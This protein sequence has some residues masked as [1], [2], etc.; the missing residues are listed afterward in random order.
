M[1]RHPTPKTAIIQK[2]C[3]LFTLLSFGVSGLVPCWAS[4]DFAADWQA[5]P[6]ID[7]SAPAVKAPTTTP[8]PASSASKTASSSAEQAALQAAL[9][10]KLKP[11]EPF[12]SSVEKQLLIAPKAGSPLIQ[13]LNTLQAVLYG[14]PRFQDAGELLGELARLFPAE[15]AKA[16]ADLQAKLQAEKPASAPSSAGKTAPKR[17]TVSN[18][19]PPTLAP[20]M[21]NTAQQSSPSPARKKRFWQ[22]EDDPFANDPFFQDQPN[23]NADSYSGTPD[24]AQQAGPSRLASIGQGLAGLAMMAGAVAGSYYLN[25][26]NNTALPQ[27]GYYNNA[28]YGYPPYG[29]PYGY[30]VGNRYFGPIPGQVPYGYNPVYPYAYPGGMT[31]N[32]QP[33]RPYGTTTFPPFGTTTRI[34]PY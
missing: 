24:I 23:R 8:S 34:V 26:G 29:A 15:A 30:G 28:P 7:H 5:K 22:S 10:E 19:M 1:F 13:R 27:N 20:A 17:P 21:A 32:A 12:I 18:P 3:A 6:L 31:L 11:A 9:E 16:A 2:G 4:S 25:R 14:E 33:Y